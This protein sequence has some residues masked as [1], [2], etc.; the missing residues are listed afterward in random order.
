[1][2]R[3]GHI[4]YSNV[5]VGTK[6]HPRKD[7]YFCNKF[8]IFSETDVPHTTWVTELLHT[9]EVFSKF[10]TLEQNMD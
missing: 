6:D 8:E 10:K 1:M 3:S 5:L 9:A 7:L 2:E 4:R